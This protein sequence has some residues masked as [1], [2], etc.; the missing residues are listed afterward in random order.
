MSIVLDFIIRPPCPKRIY[1]GNDNQRDQSKKG[2]PDGVPE[3]QRSRR[4]GIRDKCKRPWTVR[5]EICAENIRYFRK[6]GP[7]VNGN[8]AAMHCN[9]SGHQ[10]EYKQDY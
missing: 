8:K 4:P 1:T 5:D 2:P 6:L 7:I 3:I 9:G 10:N